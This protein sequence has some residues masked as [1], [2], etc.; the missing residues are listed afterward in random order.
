MGKSPVNR[1]LPYRQYHT[2]AGSAHDGRA[3]EGNVA[4]VGIGLIR[5]LRERVRTLFHHRA[6]AGN[7]GLR[8]KQII[9]RRQTNVCGN[10]LTRR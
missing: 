6:L 2:F 1:T 3:H 5:L 8:Y 7:D 10:P 9:R 4:I